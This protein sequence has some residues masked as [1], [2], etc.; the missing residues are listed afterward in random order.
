MKR[1]ATSRNFPTA[2]R[3]LSGYLVRKGYFT[4]E[5]ATRIPP[6]LC[7]DVFINIYGEMFNPNSRSRKITPEFIKLSLSFFLSFF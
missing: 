5:E 3:L 6:L 1:V 4:R 7:L 2:V